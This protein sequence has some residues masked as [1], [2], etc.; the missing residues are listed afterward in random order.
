MNALEPNAAR[1]IEAFSRPAR[2]ILVAAIAAA[3]AANGLALAIPFMEIHELLQPDEVY[4]LPAAVVMMWKSGLEVVAV[5]IVFFSICFPFAKLIGLTIALLVRWK[6]P[7]RRGRFVRLLAEL[8]R[9]SLLDVFVV[10]LLMVLASGQWVV[11]TDVK[12]GVYLFVSAIGTAMVLSEVVARRTEARSAVPTSSARTVAWKRLGW[13]GR[14]GLPAI[15]LA[16]A[17]TLSV[18]VALPVL[19]IHQFML[20]GNAYSVIS[21]VETLWKDHEVVFAVIMTALL[22][23]LPTL[24]LLALAAAFLLPLREPARRTLLDLA[25]LARR[26]AG[27]EVFGLA[28]MLVLLEGRSL[29]KTEIEAG[30]WVLLGAIVVYTGLTLAVSKAVR[31]ID[32]A[33]A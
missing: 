4:E 7:S 26:W 14:L 2:V 23:V 22:G 6:D 20:H 21:S 9:W 11:S 17:A 15:I 27:I 32:A 13:F 16:S 31:A 10:M 28:L 12:P 18:A 3:L 24:R 19:K 33:S 5:L 30:A 8:G 25:T 1:L 29:I